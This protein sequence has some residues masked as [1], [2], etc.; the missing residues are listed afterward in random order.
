[1]WRE[2]QA[3]RLLYFL[4]FV[5]THKGFLKCPPKRLALLPF[6]A[7]HGGVIEACPLLS[8][9]I[10][11]YFLT[12]FL[13]SHITFTNFHA[14]RSSRRGFLD[15]CSTCSQFFFLSC[16]EKDSPPPHNTTQP[17]YFPPFVAKLYSDNSR[18][19]PSQQYT[20]FS[21]S[22]CKREMNC[23][24]NKAHLE[25]FIFYRMAKQP[26]NVKVSF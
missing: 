14:A 5:I 20:S 10:L 16:W 18:F 23:P 9:S 24:R 4:S 17:R 13:P 21:F 6:S 12:C 26:A 15:P 25:T 7:A 3:T 2:S 11:F 22:F 19:F 8:I 1:M